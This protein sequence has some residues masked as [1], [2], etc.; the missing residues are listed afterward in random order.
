LP[1]GTGKPAEASFEELLPQ[2]N[3]V[4]DEHNDPLHEWQNAVTVEL[5]EPVADGGLGPDLA[6]PPVPEMPSLPGDD[7]PK[8]NNFPEIPE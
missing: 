3:R 5:N 4:L 1:S 8:P 6:V 7:S 2:I